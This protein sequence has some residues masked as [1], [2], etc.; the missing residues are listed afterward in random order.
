MRSG[1]FRDDTIAAIATSPQVAAAVGVIRVSGP[2]A[3]KVTAPLLK[4]IAHGKDWPKEKV[5][6]HKLQ[7]CLLVDRVG[8]SLDDGMF[9]WMQNPHSFTG[10]EVVELHLHGN[11]HLLRRVLQELQFRGASLALPGEFSFRAF[12]NG[13]LTL[14]QAESIS[15]LIGS[16]TEE[17]AQRA[18]SHL[19]GH[20]KKEI[21]SLKQELVNR[22]AEM[23]VDIDFSDQGVS[24]LDYDRWAT[25]LEK[26]RERVESIRE[27]FL[28]SQPRREG[29][30]LALVGAPN[31]GKSSLFNTLLGE[32]RSIVSPEQ[33]TTRDVVRELLTLQGVL[34]RLADTAG[35]RETTNR[36]EAQGIDRSYG[37]LETADLVLWLTD[38]TVAVEER[39]ALL[40]R[41]KRLKAHCLPNTRFV[42]IWNKAD[43]VAEPAS[44]WKDVMA[45]LSL[46]WVAV[47]A[48][49][50]QGV[51]E[52][53]E[54]LLKPFAATEASQPDF[55]ISRTRH[56]AVLGEASLAV[57][58]ALEK[59]SSGERNPDLL[60]SDLRAALS[61]IGEI[62]GEFSSEDLLNHIFAEFCIGK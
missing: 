37:E 3:W 27:E 48:A 32:D 46:P 62:T 47:S 36:I 18:L 26:W 43:L 54:E 6:S 10:E 35:L 40:E 58:K 19:L 25:R 12:K 15:D 44:E 60:A 53:Q 33:G 20:A 59:V 1:Y 14:S 11:P 16:H 9:V 5:E 56:Y 51:S 22:L 31:S 7:R 30:R 39:P 8:A 23:E 4:T 24:V 52:L 13:K 38:G 2:E 29:I 28:R 57:K 45:D 17:G 41:W 61:Q 49:S 21:E 34:F 50:G 42:A 55:L